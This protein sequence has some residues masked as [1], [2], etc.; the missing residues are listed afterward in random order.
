M[1]RL[2]AVAVGCGLAVASVPAAA[3]PYVDLD[4]PFNSTRS[5]KSPKSAKSAKSTKSAKSPSKTKPKNS[6]KAT[7]KTASKKTR[8]SSRERR[9]RDRKKRGATR[10]AVAV[11]TTKKPLVKTATLQSDGRVRYGADRM[12][13]GFA[14]P[15]TDE[16]KTASKS[17]ETA[18]NTLGVTWEPSSPQGMI[19]DPVVVPSMEIG[20]IK[21]T[22]LYARAPHRFDCQFVQ[23]LALLGPELHAIGVREVQFGSIYRNTLARSHGQTKAFRSRHAL[24]IAMDVM[25]FV[26]ENGR[27]AKVETEYLKGDPLL[28][29]IEDLVNQNLHCRQVLTPGN[30]PISHDDHFHIEASVDFTPPRPVR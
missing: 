17:C 5:T 29:A 26:D 1:S 20:G 25:A 14:W 28:H 24:G 27:V 3:R 7:K 9:K 15:A 4:N 23:T 19:V 10:L 12:P 8:L 11:E 21:Y 30:D 22:S 18:L 13:P 2:L 16:M 6:K